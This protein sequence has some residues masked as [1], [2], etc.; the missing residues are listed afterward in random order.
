[1]LYNILEPIYIYRIM[2]CA[3]LLLFPSAIWD[4]W[5]IFFKAKK[6]C[7]LIFD[8]IQLTKN[9]FNQYLSTRF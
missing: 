7:V 5:S 1:M 4:N 9:N 8:K 3:T 6:N 2:V